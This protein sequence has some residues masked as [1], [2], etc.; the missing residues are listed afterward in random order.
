MTL[1]T[2]GN[3]SLTDLQGEFG[4]T[5]PLN[6]TDYYAGGGLVPAGATDGSGNPIPS[7]GTIKLTDFYGASAITI[8]LSNHSV[9]AVATGFA[10]SKISALSTGV[11][12]GEKTEISTVTTTTY[13]SEWASDQPSTAGSDYEVL[14]TQVS[15]D[16]ISGTMGSWLS[17]SADRSW[18]ISASASAGSLLNRSGVVRLQIRKAGTTTVL[19][20]GDI[21]LSAFSD[22]T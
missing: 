18:S 19:A 20:T 16:A 17:L 6:L 2:S 12:E 15:G 11:L 14:A 9:S 3:I 22:R 13:G 21:T 8:A 1:Q 10:K 4:G 5:A 7:S